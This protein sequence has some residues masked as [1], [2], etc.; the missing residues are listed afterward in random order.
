M[1]ATTGPFKF[2]IKSGGSALY[3]T[4]SGAG[5]TNKASAVDCNITDGAIH[6]GGPQG[7]LGTGM[8]N[9]MRPSKSLERYNRGWSIKGENRIVYAPKGKPFNLVTKGRDLWVENCDAHPDG[10][11]FTKG[12]AYAEFNPR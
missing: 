7:A 11:T 2:V 10:K 3:L 1:A 6:C 5:T 4:A 12:T 9:K 8:H